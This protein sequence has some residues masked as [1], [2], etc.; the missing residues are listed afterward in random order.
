MPYVYGKL[1]QAAAAPL[2]KPLLLMAAGGVE[3]DFLLYKTLQILSP[4]L[5]FVQE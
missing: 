4:E 1:A 2:Y 5:R 3:E